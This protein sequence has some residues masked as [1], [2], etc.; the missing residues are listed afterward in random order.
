M[1]QL[2]LSGGA[3]LLALCLAPSIA[4]QTMGRE[5]QEVCRFSESLTVHVLFDNTTT[6]RDSVPDVWEKLDAWLRALESSLRPDDRVEILRLAY[7]A[8][9]PRTLEQAP[10][11]ITVRRTADRI[12]EVVEWMRGDEAT[13]TDLAEALEHFR[14]QRQRAQRCG[15]VLLLVTDGSL[16]PRDS[17]QGPQSAVA[18]LADA[19]GDL[20]EKGWSV[21]AVQIDDDADDRIPPAFDNDFRRRVPE[22]T[23]RMIR[24][25]ALSASEMLGS[26][27]GPSNVISWERHEKIASL[28]YERDESPFVRHRNLVWARPGLTLRDLVKSGVTNLLYV[29]TDDFGG[30]EYRGCRVGGFPSGGHLV[31]G[32]SQSCYHL[33]TGPNDALLERLAD[34]PMGRFGWRAETSL[35]VDFSGPLVHPAQFRVVTSGRGGVGCGAG[36]VPFENGRIASGSEFVVVTA[37]FV[38]HPEAVWVD[39][40]RAMDQSDCFV[41]WKPK[42]VASQLAH[43]AEDTLYVRFEH[44]SRSSLVIRSHHFFNGR[45]IPL[46]WAGRVTSILPFYALRMERW[47]VSASVPLPDWVENAQLK[48]EGQRFDLVP[49]PGACAEE[50]HSLVC[51]KFSSPTHERDLPQFGT[52]AF[53]SEADVDCFNSSTACVTLPVHSPGLTRAVFFTHDLIVDAILF[54]GLLTWIGILVWCFRKRAGR[55]ALEHLTLAFEIAGFGTAMVIAGTELLSWI[56]RTDHVVDVARVAL[57]GGVLTAVLV[58][59]LVCD[60]VGDLMSGT[61]EAGGVKNKLKLGRLTCY[62][63]L[64]SYVALGCGALIKGNLPIRFLA[65]AALIVFARPAAWCLLKIPT[66]TAALGPEPDAGTAAS[67]AENPIDGSDDMLGGGAGAGSPEVPAECAEPGAHGPSSPFGGDAPVAIQVH[68]V[69]LGSGASRGGDS[70]SPSD[71]PRRGE[72]PDSDAGLERAREG[73][74]VPGSDASGPPQIVVTQV[75]LPEE[76]LQF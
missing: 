42:P 13:K 59:P 8:T 68:D 12:P 16:D 76:D 34:R 44:Y 64:S 75:S 39:T 21:F 4:G 38:R 31:L 32:L 35:R 49:A 20:R 65:P 53:T 48:L 2:T 62:A 17:A 3:I 61:R 19:V 27:F 33:V 15:E 69:K 18:R 72:D 60:V 10:F 1:R 37:R 45:I 41:L 22:S 25:Q 26:T 66:G 30:D 56:R 50:S 71:V 54:L 46:E 58:V 40:M 63:V 67:L 36:E 57:G 43:L 29:Q 74:G 6:V 47:H 73:A 11:A 5:P 55:S 7:T 9:A 70:D 51:F 52:I 24:R 23:R 14:I 28:L